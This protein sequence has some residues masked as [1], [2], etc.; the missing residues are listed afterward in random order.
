MALAAGSR[1]G[2]HEILSPL[3]SG[4]MGEVYRAKDTKLGREVALKILPA[5]FTNDPER[6]ARFRREAQVLASLNHPHIAQIYG[7]EEMNGKQFLVLE[8][9][10]GES[11]DK[12]IARGPIPI[13]EALAIAKQI[14]D[15]LEA[16][17]EKGIIHRDLKP[18]NIAV[19]KDATVKVLDFGLAKAVEATTG[20]SFDPSQS[21]T[22]TSPAMM[23]GVGVILG[24]AAY[25]APEQARGKPIDNRVDI[26][27][28]GAVLYEMLVG[29][30][31][32]TG[33]SVADT[34]ANVMNLDPDWG[35]L[36][37]GAPPAIHSLVRRC[38][39]KER[40]QRLQAIGEARIV[41]EAPRANQGPGA[42]TAPLRSRLQWLAWS[43][44][45]A[46]L[47]ALAAVSFVHFRE[48]PSPHPTMRFSVDLGADAVAGPRI[49]AAISPDG[50][51]IAFVARDADGTEQLA[52]R[53]L[54]QAVPTLLAGTN[55]ATD[56]FFS[57]DGQWVGF[58]ANGKMKKISVHGGSAVTL[59]DVEGARGAS[60][61]ED[62]NI[63]ATLGG[64]NN[65][66][67]SRIPD[68]GG[69]PQTLSH[70]KESEVSHRWPQI[71]PG[72]QHV[73]FTS[74]TVNGVY[75][76]GFL[77]VLSLKT[78]QWKT[79]QKGGY[80]GRYVS[81]GHK[82]GYLIF[83]HQ[84]TLFGVPFDLDRMETRGAPAPLLEGVAG[85]QITAGG[86]FDVSRN[87]TLIY[88]GGKA[89]GQAWSI[90]WMDSAGR[91]QPLLATPGN[92]VTPRLS[93]DGKRMVL[94]VG[95]Y[96]LQVYDIQRDVMT[97]L[98]L[99]NR[100]NTYPIWSP[101]GRHIV[102]RA[103]K[104]SDISLEWVRS[105]G[106]GQEQTLLTS[107]TDLRLYS[108]SPDGTRLAYAENTPDTGFDIYTLP[109]DLSDREHPKPGKPEVFL[110]TPYVEY[111]PA[112]SPD[113]H[114]MAYTSFESGV[115]S[116][117]VRPFPGPG[118]KWLVSGPNTGTLG[119]HPIWSRSGH[120]LFYEG[121]T[122]NRIMVVSYSAN[123]DTFEAEKPR[124]WSNTRI[125]EPNNIFWNMD[126]SPD[127]KRFAV[128]PRPEAGEQ[129]GSVHVTVVLN[130]VDEIKRKM[131]AGQVRGKES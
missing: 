43:L 98:T 6:V 40:K 19:T 83:V 92:Y 87:G 103:Q 7:L 129:K 101:D 124:A 52:T 126:M 116:V 23:T 46:A 25:M 44:A 49:T 82:S 67:L 24:T 4:G 77:G 118:G 97:R 61:G 112:F 95:I 5:S 86:Q 115:I 73:L 106:G 84:T 54:D 9:V 102:F 47:I 64:A 41:L 81:V 22:I 3:G 62:G 32:F 15:A 66:G 26:W 71:L 99:N 34:L 56:P 35:R 74:S 79:V 105:D 58:F 51:R 123:G 39:T 76:D 75:D 96:E 33:D 1:L 104:G 31:T 114:W 68:S 120:E 69:T 45:V 13:D 14:A 91:M 17:H 110:K 16:A 21:P 29:K 20:V 11:L 63:I 111:E 50:Q 85:E 59:C 60:W 108:I 113:G 119:V 100:Q 55:N 93:P 8:L 65:I 89:P 70:P 30:R 42:V 109:L 48:Q 131:P 80:F 12:R 121:V 38:L 130:F 90:A 53:L 125:L 128:F 72:G 127:G 37:K 117:Y 78:G 18:A 27:S 122:D 36:P 94:S 2:P 107:K 88:L 10:D 57:P 28:F